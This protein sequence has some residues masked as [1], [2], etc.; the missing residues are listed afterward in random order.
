MIGSRL[1]NYEVVSLLG[2]GGMG[3]VFLAKHT[4]MGRKAAIKI[5]RPELLGDQSLVA[6]FLD[7]AKATNAIG[8]PNIIDIIDVGILPDRR[9]PYL[10]MEFLEGESLYSSLARERPLT[11][12]RA[13][14]IA[15]QTASALAAAHAQ[16]IIHRDLKPDNLFLVPD[17][18][19]NTKTRVKVLDFGIAKLKGNGIGGQVKTQTGVILGTAI[20]MSPEQIRG[21]PSDIDHRTDIYALG[22]ILYEMLTGKPPFN[23]AGIAE[24]FMLHTLEPP[25]PLRSRRPDIPPELETAVLRALAKDP[26]Q[27]FSSMAEFAK[28]IHEH[29]PKHANTVKASALPSRG[30]GLAETV[31][32]SST[33]IPLHQ[34]GQRGG[35]TTFSAHLGEA[36]TRRPRERQG[37]SAMMIGGVLLASVSLAIVVSFSLRSREDRK[38]A[39]TALAPA[40]STAALPP[41]IVRVDAGA[42][43]AAKPVMPATTR[44]TPAEPMVATPPPPTEPPTPPSAKKAKGL[45]AAGVRDGNPRGKTIAED[46]SPMP[47]AEPPTVIAPPPAP[48][49]RVE[50]TP[51]PAHAAP[52]P[53]EEPSEKW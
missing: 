3:R 34:S 23:S 13:I 52:P 17:E 40:A 46:L 32:A 31:F 41:P 39:S 48:A 49:P 20:Y 11:V 14:D 24:L 44:T 43:A 10:M 53:T 42:T 47:A 15:S 37:P 27:R 8:H 7:E 18:T 16:Q 6:R 51:T 28:A 36:T 35:P 25:P 45:E 29:D 19:V 22:I 50:T 1:N 21:I 5:L 26:D 9:T 33:A 38:G 30:S 4:F 12:S 2:E